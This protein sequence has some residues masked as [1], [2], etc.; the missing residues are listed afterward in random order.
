MPTGD[1]EQKRCAIC[2]AY[3]SE[4]PIGREL[5]NDC[6]ENAA[7]GHSKTSNQSDLPADEDEE[8]IF[9]RTAIRKAGK[10][11][12]A[13]QSALR[14]NIVELSHHLSEMKKALGEYNEIIFREALSRE[15]EKK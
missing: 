8:L 12:L 1:Y 5:C 15:G 13:T 2:R 14:S 6:L 3:I 11:A 7:K 4:L 9:L 10:L